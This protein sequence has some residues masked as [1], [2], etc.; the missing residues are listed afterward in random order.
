MK[1]KHKVI[2]M[3]RARNLIFFAISIFG[4]TACGS[5]NTN[6][7]VVVDDVAEVDT[8]STLPSV[9]NS[10]PELGG[11]TVTPGAPYRVSYRIIGTPIVGSPVTVDLTVESLRGSRPVT[12]DYRFADASAMMLGEAQPASVYMEPAANEADFKQQVTLIPQREGRFY[13]NVSAS[14][15]TDDGTMSTLT[16][17]PIQVGTG[18]REL[19]PNGEVQL[20]ENGE[21]VRVLSSE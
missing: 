1:A 20:D 15:E 19:Q 8:T 18:S 9:K 10:D 11:A 5:E 2:E 21:A 13:L 4:L 7:I 14:F 6:E 16:A 12:L 3:T 17:I